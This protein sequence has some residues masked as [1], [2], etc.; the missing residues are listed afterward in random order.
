MQISEIVYII[1]SCLPD[2]SKWHF[3]E[4]MHTNTHK[5]KK[6]NDYV[7]IGSKLSLPHN[8]YLVKIKSD[9]W[10]SCTI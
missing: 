6:K 9:P 8:H 7:E 1:D 10:G 5:E 2:S 4:S 3:I